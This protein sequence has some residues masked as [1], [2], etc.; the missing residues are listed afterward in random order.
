MTAANR[1]RPTWGLVMAT[2]R[3][4][5]YLTRCLQLAAGQTEPPSE[6]I[7]VD[8]SPDW[9]ESRQRVTE[10]LRSSHPS[11][12]ITYVQA[13]RASIPAQRNQGI[14]LASTDVVFLIDDDAFMYPDC[15]AHVLSVY[16][17][18][19]AGQIAG[20]APAH[21]DVPPP[22]F[23]PGEF[24]PAVGTPAPPGPAALRR[25]AASLIQLSWRGFGYFLP[26]DEDFP[27]HSLPDACR[28][29]GAA[30][31]PYFQG[32]QMTFRRAVLAEERFEP[33][34][35][36]YALSEDQDFSYR[37]SRQGLLVE[38]P[39]AT[40]THLTTGGGRLSLRTVHTLRLTNRLALNL[41]NTDLRAR[42]RMR[43]FRS[44][45][46]HF[47]V[48]LLLDLVYRSWT[49]PRTRGCLDALGPARTLLTLSTAQTR[50]W[51]PRFQVELI[52]KNDGS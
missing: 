15:A 26:Y 13:E 42:T 32:F 43:F 47:A 30:P 49:L 10:A 7:V 23:D 2:F 19:V 11:L 38:M 21:T 20:V 3:R 16:A 1:A 9:L 24:G 50:D 33:M 39:T 31:V 29:L 48:F 45:P 28:A 51:Y 52:A 5:A 25:L 37:V 12:P 36:R 8:A 18:D 6:I 35:E 34:L 4:E 17:A 22:G 46:L 44:L 14:A 40:L 41:V 27:R